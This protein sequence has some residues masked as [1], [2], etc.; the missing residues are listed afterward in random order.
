MYLVAIRHRPI[1]LREVADGVDRR[2]VA[3]HGIEA[4]EHHELWPRRTRR[5]EQRFQ[6]AEIAVTEDR[7]LAT[8]P[9]HALD[10]GVVVEG[11]RND[12]AVGHQLRDGGDAGVIRHVAG[13]ENQG[14]FL[15][16]QLGQLALQFHQRMV[17]AGNIAGAAG[18]GA[19]AG[20]GLH[21]G[22]DHL[23]VL[24]HAEIVVGA[25]DDDVAFALRGVPYR[26]GKPPGQPFEI[27]KHAVTPFIVQLS[28][29]AG[30]K[31]FV[32]H[33]FDSPRA[34]RGLFGSILLD[35]FLEWFQAVCRGDKYGSGHAPPFARGHAASLWP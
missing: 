6:M 19:G 20:R 32:V 22:A 11:I 21:H 5:L 17:G 10:H 1:A 30:K 33:R 34:P 12:K 2:H 9:A 29:R 8:R 15:A 7:L 4:L 31:R 18:A 14:G 3:V 13:G 27:G 25:P 35:L 24:A 28:K 16:V 26:M 23:G